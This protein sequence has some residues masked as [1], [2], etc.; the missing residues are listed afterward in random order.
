MKHALEV[1]LAKYTKCCYKM[2]AS[3]R[4]RVTVLTLLLYNVGIPPAVFSP[5]TG[6]LAVGESCSE[7]LCPIGVDAHVDVLCY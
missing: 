1:F 6:L 2:L 4:E 5:S 7:V 3:T